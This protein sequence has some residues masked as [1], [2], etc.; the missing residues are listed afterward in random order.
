M[1]LADLWETL[2][3]GAIVRFTGSDRYLA[4]GETGRVSH[5]AEGRATVRFG[6][7]S[8]NAPVDLFRPVSDDP[9]N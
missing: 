1:T 6:L 3:V 8:L 4:T 5:T 2:P 9:A 7:Y